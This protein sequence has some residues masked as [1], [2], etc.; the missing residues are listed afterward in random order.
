MYTYYPRE[1]ILVAKYHISIHLEDNGILAVTIEFSISYRNIV[2]ASKNYIS[3]YFHWL[4]P[5]QTSSIQ[6]GLV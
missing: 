5:V 4:W 2:F 1:I 3:V 6:F